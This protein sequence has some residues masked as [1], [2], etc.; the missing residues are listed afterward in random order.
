M[1]ENLFQKCNYRDEYFKASL[2]L[3]EPV[4]FKILDVAEAPR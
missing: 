4:K 3:R 2:G 1:E